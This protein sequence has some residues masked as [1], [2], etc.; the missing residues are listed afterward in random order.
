MT[1]LFLWSHHQLHLWDCFFL[2]IQDS[3]R[4][5]VSWQCCPWVPS[6][7]RSLHPL[8]SCG[9]YPVFHMCYHRIQPCHVL[10]TLTEWRSLRVGSVYSPSKCPAHSTL[11]TG[12]YAHKAHVW[13]TDGYPWALS[14]PNASFADTTGVPTAM[15]TSVLFA[16]F[17]QVWRWG[18]EVSGVHPGHQADIIAVMHEDIDGYNIPLVF[19]W[20][21]LQYFFGDNFMAI[22][23]TAKW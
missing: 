9:I 15:L 17:H 18:D 1:Q 19:P 11:H 5:L 20:V 16:F 3:D 14:I 21:Q 12:Y 13:V 4:R 23:K 10:S 2:I 6:S 7:V 22:W 8:Y